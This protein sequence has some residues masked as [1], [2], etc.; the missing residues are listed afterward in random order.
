[1]IPRV[2]TLH[3]RRAAWC[4]S[5]LALGLSAAPALAGPDWDELLDAGPLPKTAQRLY[6]SGSIKTIAGALVRSP[7]AGDRSADA[8]DMYLIRIESPT[9][10]SA[11]TT[12][13]AGGFANFNTRL[14]LFDASGFGL[15]ANDD[16]GGIGQSTLTNMSDD[17]T[18]I[19]IDQPGLYFLAITGSESTALDDRDQPIFFLDQQQEISGP[20]G[21]GG[22]NPIDSWTQADDIGDYIIALS[23][24]AFV[25]PGDLDGDGDVDG[26]DLGL[27]LSAWGDC[28]PA[29]VC[30]ADLNG[31]GVVDGADLGLL[32]GMW[33]A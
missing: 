17:G 21:P 32:L 11:S 28:G 5:L 31:D 23:G 7:L 13:A 3:A 10:F 15:L 27:M 12:A 6:G 8:Q 1:M 26:A 30:L 22:A 24:A 25:T 20:D 33:T 18:N 14:W 16:D 4:G 2:A 9:I 29:D 19:V